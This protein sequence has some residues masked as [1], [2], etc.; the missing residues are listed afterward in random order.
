MKMRLVPEDMRVRLVV[1]FLALCIVSQL[2]SLEAVCLTLLATVL[3]ARASQLA[4]NLWKRLL[5]IESFVILLFITM[6]FA[7]PGDSLLSIGPLHASMEGVARAALIGGKIS[8]SILLLVLLL[9]TIDPIRLGAALYA[10][11]LPETLV[12][13]FVLTVRYISVI[14]EEAARLRKAMK[15]RAFRPKTNRHTWTSYSYLIGMLLVRSLDRAHRVEHAMLCRGYTG[16]YP[17]AELPKPNRLDWVS[18]FAMMA[19]AFAILAID[20]L[21]F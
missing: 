15:A 16:R 6:P 1:A 14:R 18:G 12:R 5:H 7:I 21:A 2:R 13:L 20:R 4:Q 10:L 8:T 9:G 17:Y 11:K 19:L 3:L